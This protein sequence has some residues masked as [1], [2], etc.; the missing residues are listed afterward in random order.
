MKTDAVYTMLTTY[1]GSQTNDSSFVKDSLTPNFYEV[2]H[3]KLHY[4]FNYNNCVTIG[5]TRDALA[6]LLET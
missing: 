4:L 6:L 3:G 5:S 1:I 2:L